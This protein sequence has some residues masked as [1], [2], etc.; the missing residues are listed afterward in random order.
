MAIISCFPYH[1]NK[2]AVCIAG[3]AYPIESELVRRSHW[4]GIRNKQHLHRFDSHVNRQAGS[5][6]CCV[7]KIAS[8]SYPLQLSIENASH[9]VCLWMNHRW[10]LYEQTMALMLGECTWNSSNRLIAA[11]ERQSRHPIRIKHDFWVLW[12]SVLLT[13][14][15]FFWNF[16]Q[17]SLKDRHFIVQCLCTS[18]DV[19]SWATV[20]FFFFCWAL[21]CLVC[22][23]QTD[24]KC[25]WHLRAF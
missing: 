18:D 6:R 13:S 21:G 17:F 16:H 2:V 3:K 8:F 14:C 25:L 7:N 20:W 4:R 12:V 11:W 1:S 22:S 15:C 23:R 9:R 19:P 10:F 5:C 24:E